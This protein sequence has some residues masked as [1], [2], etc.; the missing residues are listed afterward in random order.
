MEIFVILKS[1]KQ[2]MRLSLISNDAR[3][4]AKIRMYKS[5]VKIVHRVRICCNDAP[6][7]TN[8]FPL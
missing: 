3:M 2:T 5:C 6:E 1:F 8:S 4:C 7:T